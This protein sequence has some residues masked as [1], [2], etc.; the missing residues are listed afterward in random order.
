[1]TVAVTRT[2]DGADQWTTAL[3]GPSAA[4][5]GVLT[6]PLLGFE[7]HAASCSALLE[8]PACQ[9]TL[10]IQ[11][12]GGLSADGVALPDAWLAGLCDR[13]T[14][15]GFTVPYRVLELKLTPTGAHAVLGRPMSELGDIPVSLADLFGLAG[16]ELAQRLHDASDWETTFD[17]V[18]RFLARRVALSAGP[19]P[20]V[21]RA[22]AR[23]RETHGTIRIGALAAEL[24]CSRRHLA[25][26]F[27]DQVGVSPKT[28][29]RLLRFEALCRRLDAAPARWADIAADC[30]YADQPH[31]NREVRALAGISPSELVA[32]RLRVGALA[33][34]G[35]PF[36]QD[37][38]RAAA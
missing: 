21:T 20:V 22:L 32:R 31:L 35:L 25:T 10:M 29:A 24:S 30:G 19:S 12:D 6:R 2:E 37:S 4:L 11:L 5:H 18:E 16:T 36:V 33:G 17:I 1:M 34:D 26:L 9:L 27:A 14:I 38:G 13:P 3:R 15:V 7:Q 28:L 23:L 8:A